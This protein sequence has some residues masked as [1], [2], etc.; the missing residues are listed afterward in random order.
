MFKNI[1]FPIFLIIISLGIAGAAWWWYLGSPPLSSR[2]QI[3]ATT[4]SPDGSDSTKAGISSVFV[5][6]LDRE[7]TTN[8]LPRA[9]DKVVLVP[10]TVP[11]T[12]APLTAAIQILFGIDTEENNGLFSFVARTNDTLFFDHATVEDGTANIYLTGGLTGLA[13]VCDD[14]RAAIQIAETALQFDTVQYVEFY[15]NGERTTLVPR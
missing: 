4:I 8:G 13:G 2:G 9:C 1:V 7:G 14:P 3:Y 15:L 12:S 11:P 10:Y 6:L 5:A